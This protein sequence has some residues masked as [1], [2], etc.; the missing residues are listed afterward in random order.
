MD[1]SALQ[2]FIAVAESGSFSRAAERIFLTQPAISKR[3]AA[4]EQEIGARLFDRVGRKIHLT[5][6]GEALLLRTRAVLSE[7]EDIK[8]DITNLSGTIAG[9]LSVA[10]SHHIGLHRLPGPL[11]RFHETYTQV[12]LNLHF[13]DSEKACNA[14]ARG[15]LEL[16][17]VTLPP[18][19]DPP[20]RVEKIWDDPLDI[21]VSRSHPLAQVKRVQAAMLLDYPAILPGI[22]TYTR[23]IILNSFGP[24]RDRIQVGMATNY[25][26]VLKMLA[27]IGLGW[28]ALPRTM[29]DEGLKVV[30]IE[31]REIRRELGI[32]THER[33]TLSN[34]GQAMIRIIREIAA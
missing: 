30:Q 15:E 12:R 14:V 9:E 3:I 23:E 6:A 26:E 8:R 22:G 16:A 2:A 29:I 21:V 33:R 5:P 11:K 17:V 20:L 32:V 4:L 19:A 1:I 28:S 13:M 7:L 10:T 31:K 34:A 25:L 27:A 24:L 18:S